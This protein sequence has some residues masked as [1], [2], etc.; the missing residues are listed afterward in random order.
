MGASRTYVAHDDHVDCPVRQV[1][2]GLVLDHVVGDVHVEFEE[3]EGWLRADVLPPVIE[4]ALDVAN[5]LLVP[6]SC[7]LDHRL[8]VVVIGLDEPPL[9][10]LAR[11]P[12]R[13]L[14]EPGIP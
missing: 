7:L 3:S 9:R 12:D 8:T 6:V 5:V 14:P 11:H 10:R 4:V 1:D 2:N 13:T